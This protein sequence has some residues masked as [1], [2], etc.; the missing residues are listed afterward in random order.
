MSTLKLVLPDLIPPDQM[1]FTQNRTS[2]DSLRRLLHLMW[3]AG[4]EAD[5]TVAFLLDAE[6]VFNRVEWVLLFWSLEKFGPC[7]SFIN[8]VK[9]LYYSLKTCAG[10]NGRRSPRFQLH[11][12]A[13]QGCPLLPLVFALVLEPLAIDEAK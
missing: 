8:W 9:L 2:S 11:R 3:Q 13:R 1:G 10:T 5:I 12:E 4:N 6:K 7:P